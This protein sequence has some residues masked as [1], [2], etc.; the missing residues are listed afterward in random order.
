MAEQRPH[1]H[2]QV[3]DRKLTN[4]EVFDF[5][6]TLA[7]CVLDHG[8]MTVAD[9]QAISL[10]ETGSFDGNVL[11]G[12]WKSGV[13]D[14]RLVYDSLALSRSWGGAPSEEKKE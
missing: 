11:F 14:A 5:F 4:E 2:S 7:Q 13:S 10:S 3:G 9:V 12:Y 8:G 1:S 6:K